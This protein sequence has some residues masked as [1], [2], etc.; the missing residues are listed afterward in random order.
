MQTTGH[1]VDVGFSDLLMRDGLDLKTGTELAQYTEN[2]VHFTDGTSLEVDTVIY[3]Y[4][5]ARFHLC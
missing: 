4:V 3:A 1:L 2:R 5:A